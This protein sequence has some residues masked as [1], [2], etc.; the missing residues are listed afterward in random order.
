MAISISVYIYAYEQLR[1]NQ[2][3]KLTV[4]AAKIPNIIPTDM[5]TKKQTTG[6]ETTVTSETTV[7]A[8]GKAKTP[9]KKT[10]TPAE[11][12]AAAKKATATKAATPAAETKPVAQKATAKP[13]AKKPAQPA[14]PANQAVS[15][16]FGEVVAADGGYFIQ[17]GSVPEGRIQLIP[18]KGNKN[19]SSRLPEYDQKFVTVLGEQGKKKKTDKFESFVVHNIASHDEIARRAFELSHE[20]PSYVEGNWFRAENDLLN[21]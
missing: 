5:A 3:C 19:L 16:L 9:A 15:K 4:L 8:N 17:A 7:A 20:N 12:V 18:S 6:N 2:Y 11:D 21:H 10:T 14:A 1:F 13:A